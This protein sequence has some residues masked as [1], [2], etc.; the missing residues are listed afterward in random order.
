ML[1]TAVDVATIGSSG[2]THLTNDGNGVWKGTVETGEDGH[3]L[4]LSAKTEETSTSYHTLL[5]Y[6]VR[7]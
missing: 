4:T 7:A 6:K 1:L 5:M 2:W 3:E